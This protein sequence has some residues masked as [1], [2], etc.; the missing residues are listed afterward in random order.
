MAFTATIGVN[1]STNHKEIALDWATNDE[2]LVSK[3]AVERSFNN[4]DFAL[5][6]IIASQNGANNL[7]SFV[8]GQP[9]MGQNFYRIHQLSP[10]DASIFKSK[11]E[12]VLLLEAGKSVIAY[13]N[14]VGSTVFVELIDGENTEGGV[15]ELYNALG[16]LVKKQNF[17]KDETRFEWDLSAFAPGNY[18]IRMRRDDG[19]TAAAKI[20]KL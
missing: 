6:G 3:Y 10:S 1:K 8:D 16:A 7:Y 4:L 12:K 19:K 5:I 18:W 17:T 13:P 20:S 14:P 2:K 9:K 11:T 15:L